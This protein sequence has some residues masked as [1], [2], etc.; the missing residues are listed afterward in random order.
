L[1]RRRRGQC[2]Q[3]NATLRGGP[4]YHHREDLQDAATLTDAHVNTANKT[5]SA[6]GRAVALYK[7]MGTPRLLPGFGARQGRCRLQRGT[8][9]VGRRFRC[10]GFSNLSLFA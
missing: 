10:R 9:L 4:R 8:K 5:L 7:E 1:M 6:P 2:V 3:A